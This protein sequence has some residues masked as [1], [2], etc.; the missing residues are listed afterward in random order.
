LSSITRADIRTFES[1]LLQDDGKGRGTVAVVHRLL[2]RLFAFAMSEDRITRNPADLPKDELSKSPERD[3]RFLD[4]T[5][6]GRIV[7][8]VDGRYK[9]F[10]WMLA[11]TGVR[12]GEATALRTGDLDLKAGTIRV[13][14]NAPEVNGQ[15]L[16][17]Q[18][19][20]TRRSTRTVDIPPALTAMLA[21]H[22]NVYGN[23][24]DQ[25]AVVFTNPRGE[26]ISQASFRKNIFQPA[27]RR[28]GIVPVPRVHDLRHSA[29]SFM[30]DA[31]YTLLEAAQQLGHT[32]TA[33]TE[34]YSHVFKDHRQE[35][36]ARLD[37]LLSG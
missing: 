11:I 15:K 7:S 14:R 22:L 17:D 34:H 20:K 30:A 35:K 25:Q 18:P 33:M 4:E 36:V 27:T 13:H 31:G 19:T 9:T 10:V 37:V 26:P 23:R 21:E 16:M 32:A 28:A 3:P 29:A 24:F 5:E 8:E 6:V 2:H 1:D 12:V